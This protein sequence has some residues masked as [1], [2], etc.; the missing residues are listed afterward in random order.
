[1]HLSLYVVNSFGQGDDL[2]V[3]GKSGQLVLLRISAS[4]NATLYI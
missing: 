1:M 2:A 3:S 4:F